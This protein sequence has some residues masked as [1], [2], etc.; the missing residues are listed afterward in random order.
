MAAKVLYA[1][2]YCFTDCFCNF[3]V[4]SASEKQKAVLL[5]GKAYL[6][7]GREMFLLAD[8]SQQL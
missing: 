1:G 6:G 5:Q 4:N 3:R 2:H 7:K 8:M